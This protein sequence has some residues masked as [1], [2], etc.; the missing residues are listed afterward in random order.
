MF[1]P[2][3]LQL[4]VHIPFCLHKCHYCDFNSHERLQ[5]DWDAYRKALIT[6]LNHWSNTP[7]FSGR[8]LHS[9]FF[10]GGTPSLAPPALIEAIIDTARVCCDIEDDAE[11]TLEA[12]PGTADSGNFRAY[13]QAGINRLSIG[14]Q[15]LDASELRWL[16]RI[17][18]PDEA[19]QAY[20]IARNAGFTNINLDL[21]YG[22][23]EQ[24]LHDWLT[25]LHSAI[26]LSPEHLSCYQLT[27]EPH[28]KLAATH[29]QKP[30]VLPDDETALSMFWGTREHLKRAAYTAYEIS[31][32]AKPGLQCR[33][34][35]GYWLYHDY[36]GI[37]AGAS[38]KWD[39]SDQGITRY[40]NIRTPERYIETIET[41]GNAIN[42][43]ESLIRNQA[44][45]EACWLGLRRKSG[46]NRKV[47][48]QRFGFDIWQHSHAALQPWHSREKLAVTDTSVYLTEKGLAVADAVAASVL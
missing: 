19:I 36:I 14:V 37:G 20:H 35:D 11:I 12:N 41:R 27:V 30:Y 18:G 10:G 17:H 2:S 6:E 3:P 21:M 24:N 33:H 47:F 31:N 23:P 39:T 44:A 45:A 42:S 13:R 38:G 26:K 7:Q 16:E 43:Q 25:T 48:K 15:S 1:A 40:S 29:A 32:F 28:T 8:K 22:L 9:I 34:N 4:Y 5:P 46:I